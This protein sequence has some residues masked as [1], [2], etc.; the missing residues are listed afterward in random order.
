M[1]FSDILT[2]QDSFKVNVNGAIGDLTVDP[3]TGKYVVDV[4]TT[5]APV[6]GQPVGQAAFL[7]SNIAG[8][9]VMV[10]VIGIFVVALLGLAR[11]V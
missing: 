3:T 1:A 6:Y 11:R 4:N 9:P 5:G 7:S 8:I 2:Q 10:I